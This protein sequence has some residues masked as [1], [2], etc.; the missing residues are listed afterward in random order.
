MEKIIKIKVC[1]CCQQEAD[2]LWDFI[3]PWPDTIKAY[4]G[5]NQVPV[6]QYGK[7]F[8]CKDIELCDKCATNFARFLS[9][10]TRPEGVRSQWEK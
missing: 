6:I 3:I 4:G 7:S 10:I 5:K 8:Y 9:Q 1:D 2:R